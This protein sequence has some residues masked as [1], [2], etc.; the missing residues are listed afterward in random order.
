MGGHAVFGA[1]TVGHGL[2]AADEDFAH[3][4]IGKGAAFKAQQQL[5][6]LINGRQQKAKACA[7]AHCGQSVVEVFPRG[8]HVKKQGVRA[9]NGKALGHVAV[10]QLH[11]FAHASPFKVAAR[12][13]HEFFAG[14]VAYHAARGAAKPRKPRSQAA[15]TA[16]SFND[17]TARASTKA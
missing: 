1:Q 13:L 3:F 17:G 12:Q 2:P 5:A 14:L 4:H 7:G 10:V 11:V 8:A 6:H 15:R 16:A 9:G